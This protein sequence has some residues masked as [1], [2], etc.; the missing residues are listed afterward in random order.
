MS[1]RCP[2]TYDRPNWLTCRLVA[3]RAAGILRLE[4]LPADT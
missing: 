1:G 4:A 2:V 3:M